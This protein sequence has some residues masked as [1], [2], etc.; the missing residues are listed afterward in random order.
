MD[1]VCTTYS[2]PAS[3]VKPKILKECK[4]KSSSRERRA[5]TFRIKK[6]LRYLGSIYIHT[7]Q[8]QAQLE[9]K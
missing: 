9:M 5:G 2:Y 6:V 7:Q 3:C 8:R 1:Y 4:D